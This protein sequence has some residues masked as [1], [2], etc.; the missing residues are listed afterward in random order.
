M[1]IVF[2]Q[3]L[4]GDEEKASIVEHHRK[5]RRALEKMPAEDLEKE[6]ENHIMRLRGFGNKR[7]GRAARHA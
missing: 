1:L 4:L 5:L 6:I 3:E 7:A 2:E